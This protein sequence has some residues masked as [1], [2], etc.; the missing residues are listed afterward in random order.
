MVVRVIRSTKALCGVVGWGRW[1]RG[2]RA[3]NK[4][5]YMWIVL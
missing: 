3:V 2:A 4:Q 1:R 5:G